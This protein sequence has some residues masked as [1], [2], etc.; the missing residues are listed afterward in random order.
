MHTGRERDPIPLEGLRETR[1]ARDVIGRD[2]PHVEESDR[3]REVGR[4]RVEDGPAW[5]D[6]FV[7][8]VA[9]GVRR[10]IWCIVCCT[11]YEGASF[12]R[13]NLDL[14]SLPELE[15]STRGHRMCDI[16]ASSQVFPFESRFELEGYVFIFDQDG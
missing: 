1:A 5:R 7:D 4:P 10:H 14:V 2:S 13:T 15:A 12:E 16:A 8:L 6:Q 3:P 11:W 9:T